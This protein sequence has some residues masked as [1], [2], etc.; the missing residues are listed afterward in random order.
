MRHRL[1]IED[2]IERV[3]PYTSVTDDYASAWEYTE[4]RRNRAYQSCLSCFLGKNKE[5][6]LKEKERIENEVIKLND[7]LIK[8]WYNGS[9]KVF[10]DEYQVD[11][12]ETD[13]KGFEYALN[14][15]FQESTII[16]ELGDDNA[17]ILKQIDKLKSKYEENCKKIREVQEW[18]KV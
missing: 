1:E 11:N 12:A 4:A 7:K 9:R 16:K 8:D 6:M 10:T 17:H 5:E 18:L 13:N 3:E 15:V 14:Y 2:E